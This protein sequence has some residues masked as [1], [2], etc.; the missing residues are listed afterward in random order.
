MQMFSKKKLMSESYCLSFPSNSFLNLQM[1]EQGPESLQSIRIPPHYVSLLLPSSPWGKQAM[2]G[3][4]A[5]WEVG[6]VS[7]EPVSLHLLLSLRGLSTNP[8]FTGKGVLFTLAQYL[9]E[10]RKALVSA[11]TR[12]F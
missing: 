1:C 5:T 12:G 2:E 6:C 7:C 10:P 11:G 4:T 9:G 3:D 8:L